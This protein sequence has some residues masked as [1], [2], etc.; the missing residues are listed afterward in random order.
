MTPGDSAEAATL[1]EDVLH[2]LDV[3]RA[4]V[5]S[6][7][8]SAEVKAALR[9][10]TERLAE[11]AKVDLT[12]ASRRV[13]ILLEEL[14]SGVPPSGDDADEEDGDDEPDEGDAPKA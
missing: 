6:L 12:R 2:R 1:Y 10:R 11:R 9:A 7:P 5:H 4:H 3:V 8:A 13:D 14:A